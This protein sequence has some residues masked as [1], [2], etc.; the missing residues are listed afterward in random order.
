MN[1][2][3]VK[4]AIWIGKGMYPPIS[5]SSAR[6]FNSLAEGVL[7]LTDW[8]AESADVDEL[9]VMVFG[10]VIL[11]GITLLRLRWEDVE[12]SESKKAPSP[13]HQSS[14]LPFVL[15]ACRSPLG[16]SVNSSSL[17]GRP[18][19][20]IRLCTRRYEC[21]LVLSGTR[22]SHLANLVPEML[23]TGFPISR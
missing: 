14:Y 17:A 12:N 10:I 18:A 11:W 6:L 20:T 8:S 4:D 3:T 13:K 15:H 22:I 2:E 9:V 21:V 19:A 23:A 1:N 7:K 5:A 16:V